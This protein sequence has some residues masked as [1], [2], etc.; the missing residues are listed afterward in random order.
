MYKYININSKY[1]RELQEFNPEMVVEIAAMFPDE[2]A[3][4][5]SMVEVGVAASDVEMILRG[6]HSLKSNIK[7]FIDD[8]HEIIQKMQQIEAALRKRLEAQETAQLIDDSID[9][10]QIPHQLKQLLHEPMAEIAHF[11]AHSES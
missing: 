8:Q 2:Y 5:L 11:A 9:Y 6:V 7:I 4:Y 1:I 3:K 10:H